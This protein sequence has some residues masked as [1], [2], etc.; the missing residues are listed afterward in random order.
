MDIFDQN[1]IV[2][3]TKENLAV[4]VFSKFNFPTIQWIRHKRMKAIK[5]KN[6]ATFILRY[7]YP[8]ISIIRPG[9]SRLQG[10]EKKIILVV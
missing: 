8:K 3:L 2:N 9:R 10:F 1:K 5:N 6:E 4:F 7:H